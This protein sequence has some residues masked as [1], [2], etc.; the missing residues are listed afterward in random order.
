[1]FAPLSRW[2]LLCCDGV[3]ALTQVY[4]L[5]EKLKMSLLCYENGQIICD[6][7]HWHSILPARRLKIH[8]SALRS[9]YVWNPAMSFST[10]PPCR[11]NYVSFHWPER[12]SWTSSWP[13]SPLAAAGGKFHLAAFSLPPP[14]SSS[15]PPASDGEPGSLAPGGQRFH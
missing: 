15:P 3:N 7:E 5:K 14:S 1:M 2:D 12:S 13:P 4:F 9:P 6:I 10:F 8:V 11:H